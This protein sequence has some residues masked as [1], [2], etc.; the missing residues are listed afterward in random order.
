MNYTTEKVALC[1][2]VYDKVM[3]QAWQAHMALAMN[4]GRLFKEENLGIFHARKLP[5]PHAQNYLVNSVLQNTPLYGV[6]AK[7]VPGGKADWILWVEDDTVPPANAFELLR[8]HADPV[9]RPVVHGLSFDR[10]L[11]YSPS[12]WRVQE[13]GKHIE[14]IHD[15]EDNTLY[16][17]AHSGT[18]L[19]LF[20]VSAF[21]KL[22]RPWFR[23]QPFEPEQ[24]GMIPCISLSK[25]MHEAGVPIYAFT[26]CIAG[27]ISDPLVVDAKI[28]RAVQKRAGKL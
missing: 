14:P 28:S 8:E 4:L 21:E 12:I 3:P 24:Q 26:G 5:Q 13:D 22:K 27:H 16:R 6:E 19:A 17:I 1:M 23:M 20:H 18:C 25:R 11:P 9:E 2:P 15:W 7:I 10:M